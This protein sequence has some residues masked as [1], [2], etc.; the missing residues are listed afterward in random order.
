MKAS[1]VIGMFKDGFKAR[2]GDVVI[3]KSQAEIETDGDNKGI[4]AEGEA[5]GHAHR[6]LSKAQVERVK[7]QVD[8]MVIRV[9]ANTQIS[10][11]E[12]ADGAL[13]AGQ[14]ISGIQRQYRPDGWARVTD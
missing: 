1:D 2:H 6:V 4:V 8:Q 14:Y 12:H 7:G 5:T 13:N 10:H 11:E 3:V 9:L